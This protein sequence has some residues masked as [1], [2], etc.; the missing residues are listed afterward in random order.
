MTFVRRL[1]PPVVLLCAA[2]MSSDRARNA[3]DAVR[4]SE[5]PDVLPV[6]QNAELPFEYPPDLYARKV[7]ADVTLRLYIDSLGRVWPESTMVAGSSGYPGLDSAA[8][9]GSRALRFAP[10]R[11]DGAPMGVSVLFPILFRHPDAPPLPE[12]TMLRR[13]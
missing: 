5:V 7:Q 6:V 11:R 12:D 13:E 1:A 3:I 2:C 8:V 9:T 10:A 4:S